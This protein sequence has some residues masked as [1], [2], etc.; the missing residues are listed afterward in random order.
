[1][2]FFG[3]ARTGVAMFFL[4]GILIFIHEL[5]HFLVARRNGIGVEVFALGFGHTLYSKKVGE[6]EYKLCA[7][8]LGG[9]VKLTGEDPDEE[10]TEEEK[11]ASFCMASPFTRL[12]V[13][14]AGPLFNFLLAWFVFSFVYMLGVPVPGTTVGNVIEGKAAEKAGI[15]KGDKVIAIN[16]KKIT[17]W[18]E[19]TAIVH[20]SPE[21]P[22]N[23]QIERVV[24]ASA[25]R[26]DSKLLEF[27]ITPHSSKIK[28]VFGETEKVG[29]IGIQLDPSDYTTKSHNPIMAVYMGIEKTIYITQM[30]LVGIGKLIEGII[31]KET[32]GGP[33]MILQMAGQQAEA[34]IMPYAVFIAFISINLAIINLFPIPVLDGGHIMFSLI[35]MII[36]KPVNKKFMDYSM[37]VGV[38]FLVTLM[39]FA[40]YNDIMRLMK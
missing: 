38:A 11:K 14:F 37:R 7:F 10:L 4:L 21:T 3:Y 32:V 35:E 27:T 29:L 26:E 25:Q 40:F 16:N 22:L 13:A 1:M 24:E 28:N 2:D 34:G 18:D 15:L 8:P 33:I 5:G 30:T 9:Y 23:F 39:C 6:T 20:K 17:E 19:L 36:G 31:P 12:S